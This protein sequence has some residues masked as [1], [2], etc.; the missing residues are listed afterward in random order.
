MKPFL[1][2]LAVSSTT[3]HCA[4]GTHPQ[5]AT[6]NPQPAHSDTG[7]TQMYR[8]PNAVQDS[9]RA[10]GYPPEL[11]VKISKRVHYSDPNDA[12]EAIQAI[13]LDAPDR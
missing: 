9:M 8:G 6:R 10:F 1:R 13:R 11:A 3:P 2:R 5:L 7:V 4:P 12:V